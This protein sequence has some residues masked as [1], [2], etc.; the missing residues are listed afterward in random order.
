M[1][2]CLKLSS[3]ASAI[4]VLATLD[5]LVAQPGSDWQQ[6]VQID[7][8][9]SE[10]ERPQFESFVPQLSA[11]DLETRESNL[12]SL[13]DQHRNL[14][15][16]FANHSVAERVDYLI[17]W[18]RI[19][20]LQ[21]EHRV[22]RPWAK[23]PIFHL[24]FFKRTPYTEL[25]EDPGSEEGKKAIADLNAKL[26]AVPRIV[27]QALNA[28]TEASGELAAQAI[29]HLEHF[30]GVGQGEPYRDQP[31]EGTILWFADLCQRLREAGPA[32]SKDLVATCTSA[33]RATERYRDE[34][35]RRLPSMPSSAG[36]GEA[37]L[38]RYLREVR[39]LPYSVAEARLLGERE[40][41]RYRAAW[42]IT[43]NRNRNLPELELTRNREQHVARTRD[44][45]A[46]IR[47]LVKVQNLMTFPSDLP[48]EFET[49][50]FFSPRA[51]TDRHFW[52]ELQ[53]R[54]TFNNHIHASIPGHRFDG[55]MARKVDNPIRR[56]AGDSTRAEGWATYLEEM[57]LLAGLTR[58]VPRAD[59]L[60]YAALMKRASRIYAEIQMHTGTW[61]M[62]QANAFMIEN[63]PYMEEDLGRYDLEGYLRRPGSGSGYILGK[64]QLEQLLSER[65]LELGARFELGA[66][67][68]ELLVRG[69]VPLLLVR[70][71]LTGESVEAERLFALAGER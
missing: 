27:G 40:F 52:E 25:P 54:S 42:E 7:Q 53:F 11:S 33:H 26:Q 67:H 50:T 36:I 65:S 1:R 56:R 12:R 47:N 31:P 45:E 6:L 57:F 43:R 66:F 4:L 59:E 30:D 55:F 64:I 21:F 15:A 44:A 16:Q 8:T 13:A 32:I 38:A 18:S 46:K 28:L 9:L 34:L 60:F 35:K 63:V 41:H 68:D 71:E 3:L 29:F 69:M 2:T 39:L 62:D 61:S 5:P 49:D 37:E 23:D 70:W 10:L 19:N 22:T 20:A 51:L 14:H 58:E 48:G 24:G 17:V